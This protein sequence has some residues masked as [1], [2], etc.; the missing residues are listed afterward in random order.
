VA[1]PW[2]FADLRNVRSGWETGLILAQ[3]VSLFLRGTT[4]SFSRARDSSDRSRA[5]ISFILA[6]A[7]TT[8]QTSNESDPPGD[9]NDQANLRGFKTLFTML[10]S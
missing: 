9:G 3:F 7:R 10:R 4:N 5:S 8:R 1:H 6:G 2:K